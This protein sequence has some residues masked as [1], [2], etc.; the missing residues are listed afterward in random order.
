MLKKLSPDSYQANRWILQNADKFEHEVFGPALV[1]CS[2]NDPKYADAIEALLQKNDFLAFT[3]QSVQDFRTLQK[4]L[5]GELKLHD[6]TIRNCS[7]KLSDFKP[8][9]SDDELQSLGFDGWAKDFLVG[10]E[11]VLAMLCN[12]QFLFRTPVVLREISD[13]E[14]SRME[15]HN[16]IN[17]WVSGKQ[18][19][20]VNRRKEYGPGATST[21]VRQVRPARY[22]T[23]KPLDASVKQELLDTIGQL[24]NEI[25][26]IQK[27]I[28]AQKSELSRISAENKQK[29]TLRVCNL[30]YTIK[31]STS[32]IF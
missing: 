11:P 32:M 31:T 6:V 26:S 8:Q 3:T 24:N 18:T 20:K 17:S 7:S 10:P 22:W 9:V 25:G 29:T 12:E 13:Q 21:Q 5:N 16:A 30:R 23:N 2:V 14:Y 27:E 15:S 19:Y 4:A 1:T 28:D